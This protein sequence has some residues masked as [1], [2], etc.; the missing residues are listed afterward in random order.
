MNVCSMYVLP[1]ELLN[2]ACDG[3]MGTWPMGGRAA[4]RIEELFSCCQIDCVLA[5]HVRNHSGFRMCWSWFPLMSSGV[6]CVGSN[7]FVSTCGA[8]LCMPLQQSG[9]DP[10]WH[11]ATGQL[12]SLHVCARRMVGPP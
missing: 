4:Y 5:R 6:L 2:L 12:W 1:M 3:S 9:M 7:V 11:C 10:L 8:V